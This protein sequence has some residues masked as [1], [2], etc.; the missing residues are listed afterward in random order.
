MRTRE[1]IKRGGA[2][3]AELIK[4]EEAGDVEPCAW[5]RNDL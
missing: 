4:E 3:K 2:E 1:I 5:A